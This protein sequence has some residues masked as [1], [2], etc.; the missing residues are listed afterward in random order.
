M[1]NWYLTERLLASIMTTTNP[2]YERGIVAFYARMSSDDQNPSAHHT[3]IFDNV[4]TNVGSGYNGITGIFT[5][6]QEGIYVFTWVIR[7]VAAEHSTELMHNNDV[8]GA[9]FLR[10]KNGDDG[11]VSGTVV[12]HLT[13]GDVVF[14]RNHSQYVGDGSIKSEI[15]G[16]PSFSGWLLH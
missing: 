10:A 11:S 13:K 6:P 7:M 5:A 2:S 8:L 4:H 14:V 12:T 9:T 1:L 3:L 15:H 16:Q